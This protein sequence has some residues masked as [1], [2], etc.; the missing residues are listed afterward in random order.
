MVKELKVEDNNVFDETPWEDTTIYLY[1]F[2]VQGI[3]FPDKFNEEWRRKQNF[4]NSEA[5]PSAILAKA[6]WDAYAVWSE[7]H[8][9]LAQES[10]GDR[11]KKYFEEKK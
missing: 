6:E 3:P 2:A 7:S 11:L 1:E 10:S 9:E 8:P 5:D 4:D